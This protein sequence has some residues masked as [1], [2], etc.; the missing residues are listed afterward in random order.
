MAAAHEGEDGADETDCPEV[1]VTYVFDGSKWVVVAGDGKG[2]SVEGDTTE[3]TLRAEFPFIAELTAAD[4]IEFL[5]PV[6]TIRFDE[7]TNEYYRVVRA[8]RGNGPIAICRIRVTCS[9][10]SDEPATAPEEPAED[11]TYPVRFDVISEDDEP[12]GDAS[13][14]LNGTAIEEIS[15][16]VWNV[17]LPE[18]SYLASVTAPGYLEATEEFEVDGDFLSED[19]ILGVAL[20]LSPDSG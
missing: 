14:R 19:T 20:A 9:E 16:G 12:I 4:G 17:E 3:V 1:A 7:K 13:I 15:P 11:G 5:T 18:G 10:E 6:P 2:I 8:P